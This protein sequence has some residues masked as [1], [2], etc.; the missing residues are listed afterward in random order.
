MNEIRIGV[1]GCCGRMGRAVVRLAAEDAALRVAAGVTVAGDPLLGQDVGTI[2][3]V[4][5]LGVAVAEKPGATPDVCV[6]FSTPA[7]CARWAA[8]CA[9]RG[10]ALVS[11]TTGL[12]EAEQAALRNAAGRV[13]VVWAANMSVGVN[14]LLGLVEQAARAL[15]AGW[16]VE[17]VEAH[18]RNKADA[19]SGTARALLGSVN[20]GRGEEAALKHGRHGAHE[21]RNAGEIGVHAV[22]MGGVVGDHDVHFASSG[23]VLT[24]SHRAGSRD[25]FAAGALRAAKW[26]VGKP[27]GLYSMQDVLK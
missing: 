1:S 9:E 21:L 2:A 4:K 19:P 22:R 5:A 23:E 16:D 12:G 13:A 6:D 24:L 20:A 27:A 25:I 17:I 14:L 10:V 26:I 7:A 15:D 18:H 11:G 8:W 3:G